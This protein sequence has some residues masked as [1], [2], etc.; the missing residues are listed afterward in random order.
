LLPK[1]QRPADGARLAPQAAAD[2][3]QIWL[4]VAKESRSVEIA[5]R[6]IDSMTDRFLLLARHPY[7]GRARDEDFGAGSRSLS[8]GEHVIV[9]CVEAEHVLILRVV[10]GR[11]DIGEWFDN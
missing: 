1:N 11:R 8:V 3:D 5:N 4:Y 9:Y 10:H 6:L 2:L 7:L